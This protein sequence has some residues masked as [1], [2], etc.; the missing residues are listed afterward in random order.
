MMTTMGLQLYMLTCSCGRT[1]TATS[2]E[3]VQAMV[4]ACDHGGDE[5]EDE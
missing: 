1:Y 4:A 3:Q 5:D 2:L